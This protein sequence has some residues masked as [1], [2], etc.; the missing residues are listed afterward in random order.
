MIAVFINDVFIPIDQLDTTSTKPSPIETKSSMPSHQRDIIF[1]TK[2]TQLHVDGNL[3]ISYAV[4]PPLTL[5]VLTHIL[6][7]V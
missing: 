5:A 2:T 6:I 1:L 4:T 3:Y 7:C